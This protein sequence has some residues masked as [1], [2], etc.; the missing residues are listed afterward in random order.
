MGNVLLV[1]EQSTLT[2][3]DVEDSTGAV[4]VKLWLDNDMSMAERRAAC[5]YALKSS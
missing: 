5:R 3:F 1:E 4:G 2:E